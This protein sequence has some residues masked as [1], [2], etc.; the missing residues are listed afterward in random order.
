MPTLYG[1][2]FDGSEW[3]SFPGLPGTMKTLP[4]GGAQVGGDGITYVAAYVNGSGYPV[5][6]SPT[7]TGTERRVPIPN[8]YT[9]SPLPAGPAALMDSSG[10]IHCFYTAQQGDSDG[11]LFWARWDHQTESWPDVMW[12]GNTTVAPGT[13]PVPVFFDGGLYCLYQNADGDSGRGEILRMAY[14]S[15]TK[16]WSRQDPPSDQYY[17]IDQ[18]GMPSVARSSDDSSVEAIYVISQGYNG[19]GTLTASAMTTPDNETYP[20]FQKVF[21]GINPVGLDP[22][23]VSG[24]PAA[25]V[26][27]DNLYIATAPYDQSNDDITLIKLD[28]TNWV[29]PSPNGTVFPYRPLTE[30]TS[31]VLIALDQVLFCFWFSGD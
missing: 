6:Y 3:K 24:S 29:C 20:P 13:S 16:T 31:P 21:Q 17:P 1:A 8:G 30:K 28:G 2:A 5:I 18:S 11:Y 23:Y 7:A 10:D 26:W 27:Q 12:T 9:F 14:D 4:L 25:A 19:S 22:Q 15:G